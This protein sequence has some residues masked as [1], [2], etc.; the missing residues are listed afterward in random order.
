MKVS[1]II[2]VYNHEDFL[3]EAVDSA[4]AQTYKDFEVIVVVDG[5]TADP[6]GRI[7][8]QCAD[9]R[10]DQVKV[11]FTPHQTAAE[12]R[13]AGLAA[14]TGDCILLLDADDRIDVQYLEK[15]VPLMIGGIDVVSTDM[16]YFGLSDQY[17]PQRLPTIE[18]NNMPMTSLVRTEVARQ[19]GGQDPTMLW[20]DFDFWLRL[21]KEG[22]RFTFLSEALFYHRVGLNTLSGRVEARGDKAH[23]QIRER[24]G[25]RLEHTPDCADIRAS[26]II[27]M[28]NVAATVA[29]TVDSAIRQTYGNFEIILVDDG[30]TDDSVY[31]AVSAAVG[32]KQLRVYTGKNEGLGQARNKGASYATGDVLLFLDSDDKIDRWYLSKTI[33]LMKPGVGVVSTGMQRFG[34]GSS[35]VSPSI[36]TVGANTL[37]VCSLIRMKTFCDVKGYDGTMFY[38][39]WDFWLRIIKMGWEVALLDEPLFF[40]RLGINALLTSPRYSNKA[41][42]EAQIRRKHA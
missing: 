41:E 21:L 13:N 36:S 30:S 9:L 38:E 11:L 23:Q 42:C 7:A 39:D 22:R 37:P 26:I 12:G 35:Y 3:K 20:D 14:A 34:A 25:N 29:E 24:H 17:M 1:I 2:P 33:P 16:Q 10:P 15:T 32:F 31:K 8:K 4:L 6:S 27:P 18:T 40:Y 5:G 28:Y 19:V